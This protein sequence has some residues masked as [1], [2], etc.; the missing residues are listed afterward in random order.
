[1]ALLASRP[2]YLS[3]D[4]AKSDVILAAAVLLFG[5]LARVIVSQIPL[6]P[7]TGTVALVLDL[8]WLILLTAAVPWWLSRYRGDGIRAF[9][10]DG[11][12][13]AIGSGFALAVPVIV[14]QILIGILD[15]RTASGAVAGNLDPVLAGIY[16]QTGLAF[17]ATLAR[18]VVLTVGATLVISFLAIRSRDAF[19][20][21]P[22]TSLT[23]L[24]R[25]FGM[26]A[27]GI[28]L[29]LGLLRTIFGPGSPG[30]VLL[31]VAALIAVIL[32]ADR[33]LP[34]TVMVPRATIAA[35]AI[36]VVVVHIFASGGL[37]RGNLPEGLYLGAMGAGIAVVM[38][39]LVQL[40][41]LAWSIVPLMLAAHWWFSPLS[42]LAF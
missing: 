39:A 42:P 28:A 12:R 24:V 15:G 38:A 11:D 31:N 16:A 3:S 25:T 36:I 19:P 4:D 13:S 26:G 18:F 40:R 14:A 41:G 27:A 30:G 9:G 37:F 2:M 10:L 29:V 5:G 7:R 22:D 6:Y 21:S 8:V 35:P 34:H 32:L 1:V 20:R 33:K 23:E 17:V